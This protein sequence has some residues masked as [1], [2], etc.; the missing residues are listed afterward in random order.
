[1]ESRL[2]INDVRGIAK[3][4]YGKQKG[5]AYISALL[6]SSVICLVISAGFLLP[7][8]F[9]VDK[10]T[11]S[12]KLDATGVLSVSK[13]VV[14]LDGKYLT[15]ETPSSNNLDLLIPGIVFVVA[16]FLL[17]IFAVASM[18]TEENK[19]KDEFAQHYVDTGELPEAK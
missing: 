11:T 18:I 3:V 15:P 5:R 14:M 19:F 13:D 9:S 7:W 8:A 17:Y 2:S 6:W 12:Y 10:S 4:R 1:M 16:F